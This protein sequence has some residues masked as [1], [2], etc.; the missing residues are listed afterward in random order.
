MNF[1]LLENI[2]IDKTA[3]V[4]TARS[5]KTDTSAPKEIGMAAKKDGESSSQEGDQRIVDLAL[6]VV[7]KGTGE[8]KWSFDKGQS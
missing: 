3:T 6:Q 7:C 2:I 4:P 5:R 8:G 1:S